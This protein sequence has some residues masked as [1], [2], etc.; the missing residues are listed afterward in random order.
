MRPPAP[1]FFSAARGVAVFALA[2]CVAAGG[3]DF[4]V[5]CALGGGRE[6][7]EVEAGPP[8]GEGVDELNGAV[9][10]RVSPDCCP[11][12]SGLTSSTAP[13]R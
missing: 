6:G 2:V 10:M 13:P 9:I 11:P 7:V 1:P 5:D 8:I 3:W 12:G 4:A